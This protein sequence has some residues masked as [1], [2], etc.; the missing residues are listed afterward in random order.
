MTN[1]IS[2]FSIKTIHYLKEFKKRIE[3]LVSSVVLLQLIFCRLWGTIVWAIVTLKDY[4]TI[5]RSVN[6]SQYSLF[7][8]TILIGAK[9]TKENSFIHSRG[10][11]CKMLLGRIPFP[12]FPRS[13][14]LHFN[15]PKLK[16]IGATPL[17]PRFGICL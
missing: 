12:N 13:L 2:F 7:F 15:I 6:R 16:L 14:F 4:K 11:N 5:F 1:L 9:Y 3:N 8:I 10:F 17:L